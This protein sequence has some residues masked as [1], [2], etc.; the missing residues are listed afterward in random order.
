MSEMVAQAE[1]MRVEAGIGRTQ[2]K[3]GHV[4]QPIAQAQAGRDFSFQSDVG[5]ELK[6]QSEVSAVKGASAQAGAAEASFQRDRKARVLQREDG[7]ERADKRVL[8][9]ITQVTGAKF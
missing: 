9:M 6:R 7:A 4:L 8:T 3:I 5:N 1:H 2:A